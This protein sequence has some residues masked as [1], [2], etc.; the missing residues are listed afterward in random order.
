MIP[1]LELKWKPIVF[2]LKLQPEILEELE[3]GENR[4]KFG[5]CKSFPHV[6]VYAGKQ[7]VYCD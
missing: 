1:A 2:T 6:T 3:N 4:I 5:F 7:Q